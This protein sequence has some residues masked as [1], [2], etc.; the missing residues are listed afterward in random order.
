MKLTTEQEEAEAARAAETDAAAMEKLL[1]ET[2]ADEPEPTPTPEPEPAAPPP[3]DEPKP[4]PA[5]K[6]PPEPA[7]EIKPKDTSLEPDDFEKDLQSDKYEPPAGTTR[8]SRD[9]IKAVKDH[10]TREHRLYRETAVAKEA[11]EKQQQEL[12]KQIA[13]GAADRAELDRLRPIVE[14]FAIERDPRLNERFGTEMSKIDHRIIVNLVNHGL[15][16]ET[17]EYIMKHGGPTQFSRDS[18]SQVEAE[19]E[20]AGGTPVQMSH[21]QFWDERVVKQLSEEGHRPVKLAFDDETRLKE[22]RDGELRSRL[23]NREQYFKDLQE[24]SKRNE[25]GFK[26]ECKKELDLQLKDLGDLAKPKTIPAD[27]TPEQKKR[28]ET[29][30][31][32]VSDATA[33]FDTTFFD[34]SPRAL[35]KKNLGYLML[36]SLKIFVEM[37]DAEIAEERSAREAIQKKWDASLKAA[38]TSHRQSVQQQPKPIEGVQAEKNDGRRMEMMLEQ[39][40]G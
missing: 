17:A 3:A 6:P 18:V 16:K 19:A 39:L 34:T 30:N 32:M 26:A 1:S 40:P 20:H 7:A 29:Y 38:N 21:K 4:P 35:V 28:L 12:Q 9:I 11:L 25:E 14:T 23:S 5:D 37:K 13:A 27:A 24:E 15:S 22:W 33:K 8:H 10:A 2:P 36:E 31:Q